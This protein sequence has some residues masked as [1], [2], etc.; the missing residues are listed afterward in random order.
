MQ[1]V[2]PE[3]LR[4]ATDAAFE[5]SGGG[6]GALPGAA[7]EQIGATAIPGAW[8]KGDVDLLVRVPAPE[9]EAATA[10]L[11]SLYT[12]HQ[13]ENWTATFASFVLFGAAV[14]V[15]LVAAA[16]PE[17]VEFVRF[18]ER[19]SAEPA[20]LAR[21]NEL[22]RSHEG[23]AEDDYRAAKAAFVRCVVS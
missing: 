19:L 8:S 5:R 3:A 4:A 11:R 18:R 21:Y 14:G 20:L 22:K 7:V 13:L 12:P 2:A 9:L 6:S 15:Q 1:F 10:V 17:D 16:G 23:A